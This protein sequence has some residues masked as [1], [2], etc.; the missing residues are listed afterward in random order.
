MARNSNCCQHATADAEGPHCLV[1]AAPCRVLDLSFN[2][3]GKWD[4]SPLEEAREVFRGHRL[5]VRLLRDTSAGGVVPGP[6]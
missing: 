5:E 4:S 2:P 1:P 6:C 3:L